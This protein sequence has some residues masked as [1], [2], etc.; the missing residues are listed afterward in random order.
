MSVPSD[1]GAEDPGVSARLRIDEFIA[2][3][4]ALIGREMM[5]FN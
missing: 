1:D 2:D 5:F 4:V 3:H